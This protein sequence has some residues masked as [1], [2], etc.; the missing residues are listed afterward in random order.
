[1]FNVHTN[2]VLLYKYAECVLWYVHRQYVPPYGF[3]S[4]NKCH[5][6]G[7]H[8][9]VN[10]HNIES[11]LSTD[12]QKKNKEIETLIYLQRICMCLCGLIFIF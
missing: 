1:M 7:K 4:A 3:T 2:F 9:S 5:V 6:N 8:D 10:K 11:P 12:Q